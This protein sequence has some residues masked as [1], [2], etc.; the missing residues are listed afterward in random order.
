MGIFDWLPFQLFL[1]RVGEGIVNAILITIGAVLIGLLLGLVLALARRSRH[2]SISTSARILID[3]GRSVPVLPLLYVVYFGV[4]GLELPVTPEVA[5]SLALGINLAFYMAEL[6]RS[7]LRAVP[8]GAIEAGYALGMSSVVVNRRITLPIAIRVMLPAI[9]QMAV[10]TLLN[11]SLVSVIGGREITTVS[12]NII[13][14]YFSTPIWWF[15]ALTY[16]V[17]AFPLSRFF[18]RLEKRLAVPT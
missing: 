15:V 16:F 2:R 3:V 9:G 7:G 6:F 4:L 17:M 12:Q 5:G 11:S 13:N 10:G 8:Q 14:A 1:A 18:S